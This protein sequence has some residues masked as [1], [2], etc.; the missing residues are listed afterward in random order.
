MEINQLISIKQTL[1]VPSRVSSCLKR[2]YTS[3]EVHHPSLPTGEVEGSARPGQEWC[4]YEDYHTCAELTELHLLSL[5]AHFG[6]LRRVT[7]RRH[8]FASGNL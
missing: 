7:Y 3:E 8:V 4:R 2:D 6:F 1:Q 5:G